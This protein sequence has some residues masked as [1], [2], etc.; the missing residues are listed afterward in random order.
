MGGFRVL[1]GG[2]EVLNCTLLAWI[3]RGGVGEVVRIGR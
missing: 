1:V 3:Y 2:I